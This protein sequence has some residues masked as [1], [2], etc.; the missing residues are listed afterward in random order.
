[1]TKGSF[2]NNRKDA[3]NDS[4]II[5][6]LDG[7]ERF[8]EP[9]HQKDQKKESILNYWLPKTFPPRVKVIVTVEPGTKASAIFKANGC[10]KIPLSIPKDFVDG[11]LLKVIERECFVKLEQVRS[12][13]AVVKRLQERGKPTQFLKILIYC[14]MP[15]STPNLI[16][17]STIDRKR[18]YKIYE[19]FRPEEVFGL[20]D[21]ASL[22]CFILQYFSSRIVKAEIFKEIMLV[23]SVTQK[24]LTV[25]ELIRL[26]M[27]SQDDL[28][29]I[30][31]VFRVFFMNYEGFWKNNSDIFRKAVFDFYKVDV[32]NVHADIAKTMAKTPNSIR[33]LEEETYHLY[34]CKDFFVL[35]QVVSNI[36]NFLLLFN[37]I[38]KY[39]LCRYWQALEAHGYDPVVEFNKAVELFEMNYQPTSED[40]FRIIL[41]ISRFFKEI[42]DFETTRTPEFRH[43][44]IKSKTFL[45]KENDLKIMKFIEEHYGKKAGDNPLEEDLLEDSSIPIGKLKKKQTSQEEMKAPNSR[46]K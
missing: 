12:T 10:R 13:T 38:N 9:E 20:Q 24:G 23:L 2:K 21:L 8:V 25:E 19:D 33:K 45:A 26:S 28:R 16:D 41:Q 14:F 3:A 27:A 40:L 11:V 29:V 34:H 4:N 32:Q 7:V 36:E 1:M 6:I 43:P 15:Y 46:I 35:K 17:Y 5:I 18:V 30:F 44:W 22:S 42:S 37:P 39:E 31:L